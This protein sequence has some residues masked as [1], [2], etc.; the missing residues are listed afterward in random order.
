MK[1]KN[2]QENFLEKTT[3]Y[4]LWMSGVVLL[5]AMF[6]FLAY[7]RIISEVQYEIRIKYEKLLTA[8]GEHEN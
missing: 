6:L 1:R 4:L 2:N 7:D 3:D 8:K 5:G